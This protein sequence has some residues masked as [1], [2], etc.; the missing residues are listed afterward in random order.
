MKLQ[1]R[2]TEVTTKFSSVVHSPDDTV[3]LMSETRVVLDR[4]D[5]QRWQKPFRA[6]GDTH[7]TISSRQKIPLLFSAGSH[8]ITMLTIYINP[9]C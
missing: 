4:E 3:M 6:T 7:L 1:G 5:L 2:Q 8:R 9:T